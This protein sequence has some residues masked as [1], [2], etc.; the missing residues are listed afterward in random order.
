MF[1]DTLDVRVYIRDEIKVSV[2]IKIGVTVKACL[3][4]RLMLGFL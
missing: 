1:G 4:V 2:R 3:T